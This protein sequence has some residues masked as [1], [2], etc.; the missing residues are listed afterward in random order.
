LSKVEYR[1][2]D[3]PFNIKLPDDA[4]DFQKSLAKGWGYYGKFI[5]DSRSSIDGQ[6]TSSSKHSTIAAA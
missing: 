6:K 1:T 4:S 3:D 2:L 5:T